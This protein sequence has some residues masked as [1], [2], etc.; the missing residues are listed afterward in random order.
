MQSTRTKPV[1]AESA[2]MT[3]QGLQD[4][5]RRLQDVPDKVRKRILRKAI[6]AGGAPL[7]R[8]ARKNAPADAGNLK[9]SMDKKVISYAGGKV[10]VEL[11]GQ[12]KHYRAARVI[13]KGRG[14]ISRTGAAVP[15]HLVEL[16]TR[17]HRIPKEFRKVQ[18]KTSKEYR[19]AQRRLGLWSG[20]Q[21]QLERRKPLVLRVPSGRQVI[22]D[23]IDH[24]G[25]KGTG[26]LKRAYEST[27]SLMADAFA[28]K[29][30]VEL[31]KE[32]LALQVLGWEQG[33]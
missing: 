20:K 11:I 14:G 8:E 1:S 27:S 24:P 25:T 13:R 6:E 19:D 4:C 5:L 21:Y 28:A 30:A 23:S 3:L 15:I 29:M 26:F 31:D 12:R 33:H 2:G 22:V 32:I 7:V 16:P 18:V 17:P 10:V 9:R